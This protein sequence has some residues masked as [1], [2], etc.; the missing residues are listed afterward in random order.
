[1]SSNNLKKIQI[2]PLL[3]LIFLMLAIPGNSLAEDAQNYETPGNILASGIFPEN[4]LK[5]PDHRIQEEGVTYN[6]FTNRFSIHSRF[7]RMSAVGNAMVPVRVQEIRAIAKLAE[8]KNS[9]AFVDGLKESGGSMVQTTK[10]LVVHPV[11]TVSGIPSGLFNLFADTK[12]IAGQALK[13]ESSLSEAVTKGGQA[14]VGFSRNK[15]EL[16]FSLGVDLYS[17]NKVLQ[18]YLNSVSWATTGGSFTVDLGKAAV[19]GPAGMALSALSTTRSLTRMMKDNS[20]PG[21][22]RIN[23]DA[24]KNAGLEDSAI[25]R[26]L[27]NKSLT[28]RHQ[29]AITNAIV[30]L[31][32]AKNREAFLNVIS[33]HARTADDAYM[34]QAAAAMIA[35]YNRKIAP[36]MNIGAHERV[37]MFKNEKGDYVLTYPIDNFFWTEQTAGK[38]RTVTEKLPTDGKKELWISGR[39]SE[40]ASQNLQK[41]GW[42]MR[43]RALEKLEVGNPY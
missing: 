15:R 29:T 4:L 41:L 34:Y 5:G 35:G 27:A 10:N 3:S 24:L 38:T 42:V 33:K 25:D 20:G 28:P 32:Q 30:S 9:T 14:T 6:G 23:E 21:L 7:G 36:I 1:M 11:D 18:E 31:K 2:I 37:V 40:L 13:G 22:H 19:S 12:V 8:M 43:D 39:F 17:N 16:A 26:F